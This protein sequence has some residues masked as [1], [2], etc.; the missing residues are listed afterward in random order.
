MP[1]LSQLEIEFASRLEWRSPEEPDKYDNT[2]GPVQ[3]SK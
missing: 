1:P 3:D 2:G